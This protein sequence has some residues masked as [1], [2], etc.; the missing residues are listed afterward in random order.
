MTDLSASIE[1]NLASSTLTNGK[2]HKDGFSSGILKTALAETSAGNTTSELVQGFEDRNNIVASFRNAITIMTDEMVINHNVLSLPGIRDPFLTD[3]AKQ[4]V[5][6]YGRA[7]YLMDIPQYDKETLRI[8][9]NERGIPDARP[10]VSETAASLELR[11]V[12]SSYVATYF[13]DA[14]VLDSS[15]S[16]EGAVNVRRSVRVPPS[17]VALGA[18][19]KTDDVAQPWF[20][21]AGF[22]RGALETIT[23]ID[24]RLNSE[25]RDSLYE[26][27]I[28]P[29][30]N[31]PNKQFVI[32][33]QKTSQL[34]KT[35]LDRVNVRRLVL[36][37]KRQFWAFYAEGSSIKFFKKIYGKGNG[38]NLQ[39]LN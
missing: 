21:P 13:P 32:F 10:E 4:R 24:V 23:S 36:E 29:I 38:W 11:E 3:F 28:N 35:A 16:D 20:A 6:A 37:V 14:N 12:N 18:L 1:T 22:T 17:V 33:G 26:S 5:E 31:F 34:A 19:A 39:C 8:F 27:R 25:D 7:M 15:D 30:A 2:A 9:V